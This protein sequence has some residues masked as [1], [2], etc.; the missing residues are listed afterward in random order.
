ML[1]FK[2]LLSWQRSHALAL[3]VSEASRGFSRRGHAHLRSQLTRAVDSI[4]A[5]IAEGCGSAGPRELARYFDV[6]IKS[7]NETEHH[8]ID[9]RDR[10]LLTEVQWKTLTDETVAIRKMMFVY[11]KKVSLTANK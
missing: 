7:A 3:A 6:A 4:S 9:A 11:R 1:D 8:L 2:R 5:N 10:G